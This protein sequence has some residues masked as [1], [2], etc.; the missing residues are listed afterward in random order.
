[1]IFHPKLSKFYQT[2]LVG[3][4]PIL[5][6]GKLRLVQIFMILLKRSIPGWQHILQQPLGEGLDLTKI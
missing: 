3:D 1:M 4:A 6:V 5:D 2:E